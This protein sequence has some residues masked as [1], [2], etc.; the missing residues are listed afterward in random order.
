MPDIT[1]ESVELCVRAAGE[2][3]ST[4]FKDAVYGLLEIIADTQ[5]VVKEMSVDIEC[6][7]ERKE[8]LL[9]RFLNKILLEAANHKAVFSHIKWTRFE[10]NHLKAVLTG[11]KVKSTHKNLFR[12]EVKGIPH[13]GVSV[14]KN[15]NGVTVRYCVDV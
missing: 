15:Q 5:S 7:G 2:D 8:D 1:N 4:A 11:E 13:D 6:S 12:I 10:E 14:A 9:V 3:F